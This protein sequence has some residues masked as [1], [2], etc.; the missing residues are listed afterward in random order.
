MPSVLKDAH[1]DS[2]DANFNKALQLI[3]WDT[4]SKYSY[5][6]VIVAMEPKG[7]A[8]GRRQAVIAEGE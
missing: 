3:A 2:W 6:G 7:R 1:K 8:A 4:V 5:S